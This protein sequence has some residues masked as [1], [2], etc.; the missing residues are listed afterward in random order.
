MMDW[1]E[2]HTHGID[3]LGEHGKK[4][5]NGTRRIARTVLALALA[6]SN[7]FIF[8]YSGVSA[9]TPVP[10][11]AASPTPVASPIPA[12][13]PTPV[14]AATGNGSSTGNDSS[15]STSTE[16]RSPT[17]T[18]TWAYTAGNVTV[19]GGAG[20]GATT[21]NIYTQPDPAAPG[22]TAPSPTTACQYELGFAA[23]HGLI[24]VIVGD[25]LTNETHNAQNG[26]GW[27]ESAG[28]LMV[29]RKADNWTAFTDGSSTWINGPEGI[30]QR[31]NGQRYIWEAN[32][33][34][35]PIV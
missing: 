23:L 9:Q 19:T 11:P 3:K 17:S 34:N 7:L 15:T 2:R 12:A 32:P 25:C 31:L 30:Q 21:V 27:Q 10:T 5:R 8:S 33:D 24:P 16:V 35:L 28:G 1:N 4:Q 26:D 29:W 14:T 18:S 13:S 20:D 22:T 6:I